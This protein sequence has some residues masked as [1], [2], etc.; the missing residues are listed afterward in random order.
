MLRGKVKIPGEICILGRGKVDFWA[1]F[2]YNTV[3]VMRWNAVERELK[4]SNFWYSLEA[5]VISMSEGHNF[6]RTG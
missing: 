4:I 6:T 3:I 1:G 5:C 2:L